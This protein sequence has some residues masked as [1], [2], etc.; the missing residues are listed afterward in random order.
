MKCTHCKRPLWCTEHPVC[1]WTPTPRGTLPHHWCS[2]N[3]HRTVGNTA[4]CP[5]PGARWNCGKKREHIGDETYFTELKLE[6]YKSVV[7]YENNFESNAHP[8]TCKLSSSLLTL[9]LPLATSYR[10]LFTTPSTLPGTSD[11]ESAKCLTLYF[12]SSCSLP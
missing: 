1:R 6:I 12:F 9:L 5:P 10:L 11:Q 3:S 2:G 8:L 4:D 7:T